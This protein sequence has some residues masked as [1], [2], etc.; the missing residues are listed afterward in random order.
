MT[1]YRW[2]EKGVQVHMRIRV[3]FEGFTGDED[4]GIFR[5]SSFASLVEFVLCCIFILDWIFQDNS[6]NTWLTTILIMIIRD[7]PACML[8]P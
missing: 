4:K 8:A 7:I 5:N 1:D 2:L 3:H 6:L